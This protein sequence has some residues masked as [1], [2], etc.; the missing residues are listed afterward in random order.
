[1]SLASYKRVSYIWECLYSV[2]FQTFRCWKGLDLCPLWECLLAHHW[3]HAQICTP[4]S[5]C[6]QFHPQYLRTFAYS[7]IQ[8][9]Q[10]KNCTFYLFHLI[11]FPMNLLPVMNFDSFNEKQMNPRHHKA[12]STERGNALIFLDSVFQWCLSWTTHSVKTISVASLNRLY[13]WFD[14]HQ[15][16][17][18]KFR[19]DDFPW[20]AGG[21]LHCEINGTAQ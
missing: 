21:V 17:T 14:D 20:S 5:E 1:M 16:I 19:F 12:S 18:W 6:P 9:F 3:P 4:Q 10:L 2:N 7:T 15:V 11:N 8:L 13:S